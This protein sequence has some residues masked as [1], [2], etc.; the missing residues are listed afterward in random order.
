MDEDRIVRTATAA[1]GGRYQMVAEVGVAC[2]TTLAC[3]FELPATPFAGGREL[4]LSADDWETVCEVMEENWDFEEP[5]AIQDLFECSHA[6]SV[7]YEGLNVA[8]IAALFPSDGSDTP[9]YIFAVEDQQSRTGRRTVW[10]YIVHGRESLAM[11]NDDWLTV[12][13]ALLKPGQG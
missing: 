5:L 13:F 7:G 3:P 2:V 4:S 11:P 12:L 10:L 1:Y 9:I 6:Y 8:E